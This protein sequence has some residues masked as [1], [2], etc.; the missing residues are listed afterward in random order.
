MPDDYDVISALHEHYALG[1][2]QGRLARP[3]G[4]VEFERTMEIVLRHLP[5]PP[6]VVAD[7]GAGPGA[8]A[9]WLASLGYRVILRDLV[10]L[11]VEQATADAAAAGFTIDSGVADARN[12]DL[13]DES[14]DAVLLLGP[15]YHLE[16]ERDRLRSLEEARR[17]LKS[18]G[19]VYVAAISRWAP[20]LHGEVV[21]TLYRE[22]NGMQAV[23]TRVEASGMLPPLGPGGFAGYCHRP[24]ELRAE[25]EA[26]GLDCSDIVSVEGIAFA[27]S[28]LDVRMEN[29][30]DRAVVLDAARAL[31]RVP[32][33]LGLGPHL[34]ATARRRKPP[35]RTD[36]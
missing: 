27:L 23:T 21:N 13:P 16:L 1:Q 14:V 5:L 9:L 28:D 31:E 25:I 35:R 8:Y 10:Q 17:I 11:H 2:E 15:M 34:L 33:L 18:D 4:R 22:F 6:A 7:V 24:D 12:L 36:S 30:I 26:A 3:L 29:A 19:V 20:R 32:E